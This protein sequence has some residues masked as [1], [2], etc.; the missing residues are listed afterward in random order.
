M[1][2][3]GQR[4]AGIT[5]NTGGDLYD[6]PR[7][8]TMALLCRENFSHTVW[9][10]AA[11]RGTMAMA[12]RDSGYRVIETD[13]ADRRGPDD[14]PLSSTLDFLTWDRNRPFGDSVV[15][16]PPFSLLD[17][18]M[19]AARQYSLDKWAFL[20]P[21]PALSGRNRARKIYSSHPP[22]RVL[23]FSSRIKFRREG[24]E[25]KLSPLGTH[26]WAVW[27]RDIPRFTTMEWIP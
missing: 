15:T 16:N 26:A 12:L 14:G 8:A 5:R 24:Y 25:G 4:K 21:L 11:G 23:V 9:E 20:I 1:S 27:H 3:P 18:F 6:T 13:I 2:T 7:E 10:P 17:E 22:S 19:L